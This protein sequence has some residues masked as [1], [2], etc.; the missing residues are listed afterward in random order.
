MWHKFC[1]IVLSRVSRRHFLT[2]MEQMWAVLASTN[3][4]HMQPLW[5]SRCPF[6][7]QV[8]WKRTVTSGRKHFEPMPYSMERIFFTAKEICG[9]AFFCNFHWQEW[10]ILKTWWGIPSRNVKLFWHSVFSNFS[11]FGEKMSVY[12][13]PKTHARISRG[14]RSEC[15]FPPID[16]LRL[17]QDPV[18]NPRFKNLRFWPW[19]GN[20]NICSGVPGEC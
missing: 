11:R 2:A 17:A 15:N 5:D 7:R 4:S 16:D 12:G 20:S 1:Y 6:W 19:F 18:W 3:C 10:C 9:I 8:I 13:K 14:M